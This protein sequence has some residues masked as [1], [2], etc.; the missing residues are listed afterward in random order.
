VALVLLWPFFCVS[1][2]LKMAL[3]RAGAAVVAAHVWD[4]AAVVAAHIWDR[5]G[6]AV[7]ALLRG[8]AAV[9]VVLVCVLHSM[10]YN[11][12]LGQGT[13]NPKMSS[14]SYR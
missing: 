6:A 1:S 12:F 8:G 14:T 7:V 11:Q 4:R 5:A 9:V 3:V 13:K 2:V 10:K